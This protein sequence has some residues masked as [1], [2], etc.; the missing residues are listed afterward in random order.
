MADV[1]PQLD[2]LALAVAHPGGAT[3]RA[4][5]RA[6]RMWCD[7]ATADDL[8]TVLTLVDT[9]AAP[10]AVAWE[11][12]GVLAALGPRRSAAA[13]V[14]ALDRAARAV[15]GAAGTGALCVTFAP[16]GLVSWSAAGSAP[17]SAAGP[18]GVHTL[19][20]DRGEP[21]GCAR[22]AAT[23]A[24][25]QLAAGTTVVLGIGPGPAAGPVT[26]ALARHH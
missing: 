10:D 23:Q 20:G 11:L 3:G 22:R 21:L 24:R 6:H 14:D 1:L 15:P 13:T 7:V 12:G 5:R 19:D 18:D 9:R 4:G 17:P 26:A 16:D 2:G 25:A 8:H